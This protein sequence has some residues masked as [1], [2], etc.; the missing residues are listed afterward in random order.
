M[1]NERNSISG[2]DQLAGSRMPYAELIKSCMSGSPDSMCLMARADLCL[3]FELVA[4]RADIMDMA[5]VWTHA[6]DLAK[7]AA[8]KGSKEAK[9]L[10]KDIEASSSDPRGEAPRKLLEGS[11][12]TVFARL[13]PREVISPSID[14]ATK[15]EAAEAEKNMGI[16]SE[17]YWIKRNGFV[18]D[19]INQKLK[20]K[21]GIRA[22]LPWI[23]ILLFAA[24]VWMFAVKNNLGKTFEAGFW[25]NLGGNL[26][27]AE[28]IFYSE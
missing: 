18:A 16:D 9:S 7:A 26:S 19:A 14:P 13:D 24:V 15:S 3:Y 25:G 2:K 12:R 28:K 1:S 4:R 6:S 27:A 20:Q 11:A 22:Y 17:A 10:I 8:D 21:S 23:A 5:L